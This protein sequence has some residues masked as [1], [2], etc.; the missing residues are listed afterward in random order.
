MHNGQVEMSNS[1]DVTASKP[2]SDT[3]G[4]GLL[5]ENSVK[6][7]NAELLHYPKL[8]KARQSPLS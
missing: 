7:C 1:A 5:Q 2:L 8:Y 4:K 6:H 3:M